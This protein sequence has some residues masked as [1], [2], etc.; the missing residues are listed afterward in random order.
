M[1]RQ[2]A[3]VAAILLPAAQPLLLG[4]TVTTGTLLVSQVPAHAQ[5]AD[6]VAKVAQAITVRIEGATQGSGVL[7]KR[8]GNRYTVLTAWHVVSDQKTG[9][10]LDIYTSDGQKH[11]V[12]LGSIKRLGEVDMVVLTFSSG[13][14]YELARVGDVKS[15]SIGSPIYVSGYSL[16]G[17]T[18]VTRL[19]RFLDGKV[20]ANASAA[21]PNGYQL[22]YSNETLPGMSGGAALNSQGQ[23]IGIHGR[24]GL[25]TITSYALG[26][27]FKSNNKGIPITYYEN[28]SRSELPQGSKSREGAIDDNIVSAQDHEEAGRYIESLR[29]LNSA[30]RM[31]ESVDILLMR[32]FILQK[33]GNPAAAISDYNRALALKPADPVALANRASLRASTGNPKE[34]LTDIERSLDAGCEESLPAGT[35]FLIRA[36]INAALGNDSAASI[37]YRKAIDLSSNIVLRFAALNQLGVLYYTNDKPKEALEILLDA[38]KISESSF[39]VHSNIGSAKMA[40]EDIRGAINSFSR[41]IMLNPSYELAYWK[42]AEAFQLLKDYISAD[43]DYSHYIKLFSTNLRPQA[44]SEELAK[45]YARRGSMRDALGRYP[46]ALDDYAEAIRLNPNNIYSYV[47]RMVRL[48]EMGRRQEACRDFASIKRLTTQSAQYAEVA[49]TFDRKI[50]SICQ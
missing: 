6:A 31:Q 2:L 34:A 15:V 23:L 38:A 39:L 33:A 22:L 42:R 3:F 25:D 14:S 18:V 12:E 49:A 29:D 47:N 46:E 41:A 37:D 1:L 4:T 9:E 5:R 48:L 13:N 30:I 17:S 28:V 24:G 7:V 10:E 11:P 32:A 44:S 50:S 16:P 27:T 43:R 8:D 35:C 21:T 20:I 40:L 36:E 45:A 26:A 19:M